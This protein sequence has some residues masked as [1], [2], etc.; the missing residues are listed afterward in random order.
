[1]LLVVV[2]LLANTTRSLLTN[3]LGV[4]LSARDAADRPLATAAQL[5]EG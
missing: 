2:L 5:R 3:P 4:T 1:V